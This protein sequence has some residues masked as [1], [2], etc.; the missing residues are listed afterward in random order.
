MDLAILMD[1]SNK[2]SESDFEELKNFTISMMEKLHISQKRIRL[3]VLEYR[4]GSHIYL[5][6]KDIKKSTRMKKIVKNI[7]YTGGDVASASE[8]L[9]YVVFHVFNK[10]PRTNAA[11]I[12]MIFM[13]SK[14]PKR[15]QGI[16]PILKKKKIIVIPVGLGPHVSTE[17][18]RLLERQSPENR[19]FLM[20][21]VLE[22]RQRK[23]EIIDYFCGLVPDVSVVLSTQ[24]P[25]PTL[26]SVRAGTYPPG[27]TEVPSTEISIS[28]E[29]ILDIV[30][31]IEGSRKVGK[32]NFETIKEFLIRTI[33]E[34]EVGEETVHISI[35]QYSFTITVEHSF[36]ER[37]SKEVLIKK[38]REMKFQGGNATNTGQA[39]N[40]ISEQ[41]FTTNRRTEQVPH[42]V[43]M[44]TAN[45]STDTIVRPPS[46]VHLIPIGIKPGADIQE[47]K[48]LSQP[49]A[50]IIIEGFNNLIKQGPDLVLKTCCSK[51]GVLSSF[52]FLFIY[53][54]KY[55]LLIFNII[56][57]TFG[58]WRVA[59]VSIYKT[60]NSN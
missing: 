32:N 57:L 3:A 30:F 49:Q 60:I 36:R 34:L 25:V 55:V 47:L 24:R 43:Y 38:V 45:P 17:Q 7:K 37:Q 58:K 4:T 54:L 5:G 20:N 1:G 28:V 22:L 59:W 42:L 16:F 48:E 31:V 8:V 18:I 2:L 35:L 21:S 44:V 19:A 9:K 52:L 40:F 14:D 39:L 41:S 13:A 51:N 27:L 10:A 29:K 33:Q 15:I 26:P 6:L 12:A 11:R 23:D 53:F 56:T 46:D 50:P